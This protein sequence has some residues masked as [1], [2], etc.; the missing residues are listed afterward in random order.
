MPE[1]TATSLKRPDPT[2]IDWLVENRAEN[3]RVSAKLYSLLRSYPAQ[4]SEKDFGLEAQI[5]VG[6]AFS[7][8]RSAFLS[9][10]TGFREEARMGAELFLE[11]MLLNNAIA[12]TQDR[13]SK[14]WTFTY[15][16]NNARYRLLDY[17]RK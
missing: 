9:D 14:D 6:V 17:W 16:A 5:L 13:K 2:H 11:E 15:Y 7:L 10:K 3:Q 12:Y 8:W 4:V 1:K